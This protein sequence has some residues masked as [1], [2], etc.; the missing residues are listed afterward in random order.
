[1][2]NIWITTDWHLYSKEWNDHHP[3]Q[4]KANLERLTTNFNSTIGEHDL[5]IHLGDICDP[6]SADYETMKKIISSI[7]GRKILVRGN[8][9]TEK[10][11][12]YIGL[13]FDDVVDV[14]VIHNMIFT[15]KPIQVA[16]DELN[17]HGHLHS[18]KL[19]SP[20]ING[21]RHINAFGANW[22]SIDQPILLE[23]LL[24]LASQQNL[25]LDPEEEKE[26]KSRFVKDLN[27]ED[28]RFSGKILLDL[29]DEFVLAPMD[30][31]ASVV[32]EGSWY[33]YISADKDLD[34]KVIRPTKPENIFGTA[35]FEK[36]VSPDMVR[37]PLYK[38]IDGAIRSLH[39]LNVP[40]KD[41]VFYVYVCNTN[42]VLLPWTSYAPDAELTGAVWG[43]EP[44]IALF[45]KAIQLDEPKGS[46][47]NCYYGENPDDQTEYKKKIY[48]WSYHDVTAEQKPNIQLALESA[49][50]D[51]MLS[52]ILFTDTDSTKYWL[53]DDRK[54]ID[55]ANKGDAERKDTA[56]VAIDEA[57]K[58]SIVTAYAK[59][60]D[61]WGKDASHNVLYITGFSGSGKSTVSNTFADGNTNIIHLDDYFD[62]P[63][64]Q[65]AEFN[66]FLKKRG[67]KKPCDVDR[68]SWSEEKVLDR[69]EQAIED[70]GSTQ[71]KNGKKVI[72]EGV[73]IIDSG[74]QMNKAF[75]SRK[76]LIV[77]DT[78]F[79]TSS[80]RAGM[81]DGKGPIRTLE[82]ISKNKSNWS[83]QMRELISASSARKMRLD[84]EEL[85][86]NHQPID[87]AASNKDEHVGYILAHGMKL[88][89]YRKETENLNDP[90][91]SA[92]HDLA[93][94]YGVTNVANISISAIHSNEAF[95][96][97]FVVDE[98]YRNHGIGS[99]I[100]KYVLKHYKVNELTVE[101]TNYN[102]IRFYE[103][104]GFKEYVSFT[105][106]NRPMI[107]MRIKRTITEAAHTKEY[108]RTDDNHAMTS[109][110][111]KREIF[112]KY[113][114]NA[115][116]DTHEAEKEEEEAR[117]KREAEKKLKATQKRMKKAR[118]AKKRKAFFRK[119]KSKLPKIRGVKNE[120]A[121][122]SD[123]EYL[124]R[125]YAGYETNA[126]WGDRTQFFVDQYR[127]KD[128]ALDESAIL[129]ELQSTNGLT[130][131][132][133]VQFNDALN[134][135][136][137]LGDNKE[138]P[139]Q[140]AKEIASVAMK[141]LKDLIKK[142]Q[143]RALKPKLYE[144]YG[145][146][147]IIE[148]LGGDQDLRIQHSKE[149]EVLANELNKSKVLDPYRNLIQ[150]I[151]AGDGDEGCVYIQLKHKVTENIP[152][153]EAASYIGV[154]EALTLAQETVHVTD[155]SEGVLF[156]RN[157]PTTSQ[158]LTYRPLKP[159]EKL[160]PVYVVVMHTGSVVSTVIKKATGD[161]YSHASISFDPSL[162]NMYSFG[163]KRI[164]GKA[165][166][167]GF[168]KEDIHNE[169]FSSR[170]IPYAM[171]M[172]PVT[173]EELVAM[174]KRL[175][176]FVKNENKFSFDMIGLV[177]I[178]FG[179][180]DNPENRYFCSR[181][182]MDVLNAGRPADPY[183]QE[184][185]LVKP[186][187]LAET[188]FARYV[189]G[190][191]LK[192]YNPKTC[193][194][195]TKKLL[196]EEEVKR[197]KIKGVIGETVDTAVYDINYNNPWIDHILRY[198][199]TRMDESIVDPFIR[200]L[201]SFKVRIDANGDILVTRREYDQL[202]AHFKNS[203][204]LI[205]AYE[206]A[207]NLTGVKDELCKIYYMVELI[208]TY[209]LRQD[210][211]NLRDKAADVRKDMVDLR[212]IMLNAFAQHMRYVT[213]REPDWNFKTYYDASKY[214]NDFR[215]PKK[216]LLSLGKTII[217]ALS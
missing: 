103:R 203:L 193:A 67:I 70:F 190:G 164:K 32:D 173:K 108:E 182:V 7:P 47:Y 161:L 119:V 115:V 116:G 212:S 187:D 172:V 114:I 63:L 99:E 110:E 204:K 46:G 18:E 167:N 6:E 29:T 15:H 185:S 199:F 131:L 216:F 8:H 59:N 107:D 12:Y 214:G 121:D 206:N 14:L 48:D 3:H 111:E 143:F 154:R 112:Q 88:D 160:Y 44:V 17:I 215:I 31:E 151:D 22:N 35:L 118:D 170:N 122:T 64:T 13:G 11:P 179:I 171:Y 197:R 189:M 76:C 139:I 60:I 25:Q 145:R 150:E 92:A 27:E 57:G 109:P 21:Y 125:D 140:D 95:L 49:S 138:I 5:L 178:F 43:M 213:T 50:E 10:D 86:N 106:N 210:V 211:K 176:Y 74:I 69:F 33:Y 149:F 128:A 162:T 77:L 58:S 73:Q 123:A 105:E 153:N 68:E 62:S 66:E 188:N 78:N 26:I 156:N 169:F 177:K 196:A 45:Y 65:D 16:P 144:I 205:K 209:Y 72:A 40:L 200:Y 80:V 85:K 120:D 157:V 175:D 180:A 42:T 20:T 181:F 54:F 24:D 201:Q 130:L 133:H 9:D 37:V 184:E 155:L 158:H 34:H 127:Y 39:R 104:F 202:N 101:E 51:E 135:A 183:T 137:F 94:Y 168:K 129:K 217:T 148:V 152:A 79:V 159:N 194:Y 102:A 36:Q 71:Y 38:T 186:Q 96:Y 89:I 117:K 166:A 75:F 1:M 141:Q 61:Q 192:D 91:D 55:K 174:K 98:K 113:G 84:L 52:E 163:N 207:G 23:D 132:D 82:T 97:N 147:I 81:R 53:A 198:Q 56:N 208:N 165:F 195:L 4:S 100:L 191:Y 83:D 126:L 28:Y 30:E 2:E 134:E 142:H 19:V 90:V 146:D 41:R 87:E 93:F 124:D 136:S